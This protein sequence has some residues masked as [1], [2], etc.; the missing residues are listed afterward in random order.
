MAVKSMKLALAGAIL[1]LAS[2]PVAAADD[3]YAEPYRVLRDANRALDPFLAASAYAEDGALIFEAPGQPGETFRGVPA[4]RAAYVRTFS[5]VDP[6]APIELEFRFPAPGPQ[7]GKHDGVY[8]LKTK[9]GG[10]PYVAY[11]R[12]TVTLTKEN[13][14]WRFA[15][16]R[17]TIASAADFDSLPPSG[18]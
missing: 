5:Q 6:G 15:E 2:A 1:G 12:F 16:D 7:A 8:R 18:F 13:G 11:G 17:G 4:I 14:K 3:D 10:R 9:A